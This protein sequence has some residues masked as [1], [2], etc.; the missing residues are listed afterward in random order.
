[1]TTFST[2]NNS[3]GGLFSTAQDWSP[4]GVPN[5][6]SSDAYL[7][8]LSQT[9]TVTS[10]LNE[11]LDALYVGASGAPEP[12]LQITGGTF[13]VVST[14]NPFS[15]LYNFGTITVGAATLV[16]GAS[17]SGD[18]T[19]IN[20]PGTVLLAGTGTTA[21]TI[22]TLQINAPYMGLYGGAQLGVSA[23]GQI[24]GSTTSLASL[25]INDGTIYG[26]GSIGNGA[27]APAGDG[28]SLVV[29][30][31]GTI[32]ANGGRAMVLNTGANA[33][34]NGGLIETTSAAGLTI[35]SQMFQNG[36]LVAAGTGALT[37]NGAEL[38][39]LGN[40]TTSN[41][42]KIVL[43]HGQLTEGGLVDIGSATAG[44]GTLTTTAGDTLGLLASS[45][46][47]FAGADVLSADT[48]NYG[49]IS[50]ANDST[51]NLNATITSPSTGTVA[52]NGSTGPTKL[53][54]Y[55]SGASLDGGLILLSNSVQNSIVSDGAGTQLSNDSII[56]GSGTIGDGW[57]RLYNSPTGRINAN[58]AVG[59][60][61]VADADAVAAGTESANY[62]AG[63]ILTSGSGGLTIDSAFGNAGILEAMGPG[64]L[65]INGQD[66]PTDAGVYTGGGI[67]EALAGGTIVL[68]NN[69]EV[70]E[71]GYLSI[72]AGGLIRTSNGDTADIV[73]DNLIS[74]GS[75]NV[76]FDSTAILEGTWQ[77]SGAV[78]LNGSAAGAAQIE[79][80][81][82][83]TWTL[84]DGGTLTLNG[85]NDSILSQGAGT[86]F[87]NR[88]NTIQGAGAIGDTNM[89]IENDYGSTIDAVVE[90]SSKTLTLD[91]TAYDAST[92]TT[93]INNAGT[94]EAGTVGGSPGATLD[95][96]SA[97]YNSQY[98][99]ANSGSTVDAQ[100]AVYGP[101]LS[102]IRGTGSIEFGA[103]ADNDVR[104][105]QGSGGQLI[106]DDSANF[107]CNIY[108]M[109]VGDSVDLRDFAYNTADPSAMKLGGD[110][111]FSYLDGSVQINNGTSLSS[112]L[113]LDGDYQGSTWTFKSDT[114]GGTIITLASK[115]A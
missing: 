60:T 28:L 104:Y 103:E 89:T 99:I 6:G 5:S 90:G 8:P 50:V 84:L 10:D 52:L 59:L 86:D 57:L 107:Y 66:L 94:V 114:H 76:R 12:T 110:T 81:A 53:E 48:N 1:M 112:N 102:I 115:P 23:N 45:D 30:A 58:Q 46:D 61:I 80:E 93:Y 9:Y 51:L 31:L 97:M 88:G 108:Q 56:R 25:Q 105:A 18:T 92:Q 54:I 35:D 36:R 62:S 64:A 37:I 65:T 72:S 70:I 42:G 3:A 111:G 32:N 96:D 19:E 113:Y 21:G 95:I 49:T 85:F 100:D 13:S 44:G 4:T 38:Q 55:G 71:Q 74:S 67:V 17:A 39:G 101:G 69:A 68:E 77:N 63:T 98:L 41:V 79:I 106:L 33:I 78:N 83:K 40:T 29:T 73:E 2:W 34:T 47:S 75:F 16:L 11:T 26:G 82:G 87:R 15:N 109:A 27:S 43:H 22:A 20:G 24:L 14:A 7:Q 91:A